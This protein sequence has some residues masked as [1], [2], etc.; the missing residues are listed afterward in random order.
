MISKIS[1]FSG[2]NSVLFNRITATSS[3]WQILMMYTGKKTISTNWTG[4]AFNSLRLS[5]ASPGTSGFT[6]ASAGA[7]STNAVTRTKIGDG[8]GVYNAFFT[9]TNITKVA[10]ID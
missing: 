1:N 5:M 8:Q 6:T 2:P 9:Q 3:G 4:A 10:F 7:T